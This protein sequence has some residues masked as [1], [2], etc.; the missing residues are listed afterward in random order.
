MQ[1]SEPNTSTADRLLCTV[2]NQHLCNAS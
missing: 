1:N 2:Y